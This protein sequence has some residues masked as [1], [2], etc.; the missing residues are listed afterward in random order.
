[1]TSVGRGRSHERIA[2]KAL[3]ILGI[4]LWAGTASA[5]RVDDLFVAYD[6]GVF[7]V[8]GS[9]LIDAPQPAVRS[10]L[11]DF[12][13]LDRLTPAILESH[14]V[15]RDGAAVLVATR[16]RACAGWFCRE[17]R[18]VEKVEVGEGTIVATALPERS[19]VVMSVTRWR[20]NGAGTGTRV[21]W[22][23]TF[24]PVFM[25]PPLVGPALI[26]RA[27]AREATVHAD[28][29]ERSARALAN[30]PPRGG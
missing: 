3:L 26:K 25:V 10:V 20:I 13:H 21:L 1:M 22:E 17:L 30:A 29:I 12:E 15:G 23:S 19:N 5:A 7:T 24:D 9:F 4:A 27:L 11:T 8:R 6:K 14:V 28:S 2:L 18:K 16:S